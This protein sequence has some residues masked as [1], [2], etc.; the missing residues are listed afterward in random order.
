MAPAH[1]IGNS[2]WCDF[3]L[4]LWDSLTGGQG[5]GV[6]RPPPCSGKPALGNG[7]PSSFDISL[8]GSLGIPVS[9]CVDSV[10][11]ALLGSPRARL[12]MLVPSSGGL[13]A[14][15]RKFDPSAMAE[16]RMLEP[17]GRR[18]RCPSSSAPVIDAIDVVLE[19]DGID[20]VLEIDAIDAVLDIERRSGPTWPT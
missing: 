14:L 8:P 19:I 1:H 3:R 10:V 7:S 5:P 12:F 2:T 13:S 4:D 16:S 20:A 18:C 11:L 17:R 9:S 15:F 6:A